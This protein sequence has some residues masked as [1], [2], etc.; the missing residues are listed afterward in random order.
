MIAH[1]TMSFW[2]NYSFILLQ[3]MH[4]NIFNLKIRNLKIVQADDSC[5]EDEKCSK[6]VYRSKYDLLKWS[7]HIS[8]LRWNR[9]KHIALGTV[10]FMVI[11]VPILETELPAKQQLWRKYKQYKFPLLFGTC[12]QC[13][14][15]LYTYK[16]VLLYWRIFSAYWKGCFFHIWWTIFCW[17]FQQHVNVLLTCVQP[18]DSTHQFTVRLHRCIHGWTLATQSKS[19]RT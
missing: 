15:T 7:L 6:H 2:N 3:C 5:L 13:S 1:R 4:M 16:L 9:L 17:T 12:M 11:T 10:I 19:T 14:R 18:T 8:C